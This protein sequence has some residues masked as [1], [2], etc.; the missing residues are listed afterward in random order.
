M[1]TPRSSEWDD[2]GEFGPSSKRLHG[3]RLGDAGL[4]AAWQS[5]IGPRA[6]GRTGRP[7][8]EEIESYLEFFAIARTA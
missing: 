6:Y 3:S 5:E 8:L 4:A 2:L 7:L 1:N